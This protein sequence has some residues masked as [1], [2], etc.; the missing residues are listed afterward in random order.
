[1]QALQDDQVV[2]GIG[3]S[4]TIVTTP[5]EVN[6]AVETSDDSGN[7]LAGLHRTSFWFWLVTEF[8]TEV[9]RTKASG[10]NQST[11]LSKLTL[12]TR[13]ACKLPKALG[14]NG[15]IWFSGEGLLNP[16]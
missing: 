8:A 1:V 10:W 16:L 11:A 15:T 7:A 5:R 4:P 6:A 14:T 2:F 13:D 9:V 12:T 3:V